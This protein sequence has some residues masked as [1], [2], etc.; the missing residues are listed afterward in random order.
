MTL[1]TLYQ[2]L[3]NPF[4]NNSKPLSPVNGTG[5]PED[6]K[7]AVD[8]QGSIDIVTIEGIFQLFY[9]TN[10]TGELTLTNHPQKATFHFTK[11]LLAWGSLH[12]EQKQ[13]GRR[14][15]NSE[16]ITE[17]QLNECLSIQGEEKD[18][19]RIGEILLQK[20]FLQSDLLRESLKRQAKEAFFSV[21]NW[22][23]GT[24]SFISDAASENDEISISER[25]DHLLLEGAVHIDKFSD[26]QA[27][28]ITEESTLNFF[29]VEGSE[30]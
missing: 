11:G 22:T 30:Q 10:L 19:K 17:E 4:G 15:I 2:R 1:K 18:K 13:I 8:F 23:T 28:P 24:F 14:L 9:L 25:I 7:S 20:G 26:G 6:G 3:T 12:T 21:L 5:I 29:R 27:T 16:L